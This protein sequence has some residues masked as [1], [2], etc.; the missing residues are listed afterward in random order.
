MNDIHTSLL[1][2]ELEADY[3]RYID[4]SPDATVYHTIEWRNVI[5]DTYN[6]VPFYIAAFRNTHIVGVLPL[7]RVDSMLGGRRFVSL[8]FSHTCGILFDDIATL[9]AILKFAEKLT[10]DQGGRYLEIKCS[11]PLPEEAKPAKSKL[12]YDSILKLDNDIDTLWKNLDGSTR[13]GVKKGLSSKLTVKTGSTQQEFNEFYNLELTTRKRQGSPPYSANFFYNLSE[14][15]VKSG[16]LVVHLAMHNGISIAGIVVAYHKDKAIYAYGG[17]LNDR[18]YL[19]MRPNNLLMW[20]AI[21]E[22]TRRGCKTFD[23]GTTDMANKGLLSFKRG[24]GCELIDI[25]YYY[26]LNTANSIPHINRSS[27]N[28]RIAS[29]VLHHTPMFLFK[30]F[31]PMLLKQLG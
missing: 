10:I 6:Y 12:V 7:F 8:P 22:S 1:S 20:H 2:I 13:R 17:S 14:H 16:D 31:G 4:Q 15:F 5:A 29:Q 25:P 21:D 18:K 26:F 11:T 27:T 9:T 3:R 28:F 24:W 23:F 19:L 30:R